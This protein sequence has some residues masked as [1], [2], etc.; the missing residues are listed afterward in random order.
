M[1]P[2]QLEC[3]PTLHT[4]YYLCDEQETLYA[5]FSLG[6][7]VFALSPVTKQNSRT[8]FTLDILQGDLYTSVMTVLSIV[9]IQPFIFTLTNALKYR[10][11]R[12][13]GA[14]KIYHIRNF[15]YLSCDW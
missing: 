7:D 2:S 3:G 5:L 1:P 8:P 10:P 11:S 9:S 4:S 14:S 13:P 12:A 6:Q 15:L